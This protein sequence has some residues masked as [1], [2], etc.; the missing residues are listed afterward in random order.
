MRVLPCLC[1][2]AAAG[3]CAVAHAD[4]PATPTA[5][6]PPAFER[7]V[8]PVLKASCF[9]C[10]GENEEPEGGL[11][12]RL[13]RRIVGGG[14]SGPAVV[15]GDHNASLLYQRVRDGEMPPD[16]AHRLTDS[17]IET[18]ARWID[19]GAPT[20]RPEPESIDGDVFTE[21]ELAHWAWQPVTR[22][23]VPAV[24]DRARL[25][26]PIDAFLLARLQEAGF[27]FSPEADPTTLLRRLFLD[28]IGLPPT[29]EQADRFLSDLQPGAYERLVDELL[30]SPH[31]GE[32]WGRHWLDAAGYADSEGYSVED[33]VR[34][35]AWK[36]RDYV[37]RAFN[38]DRPFDRFIREQ[39][40]GDEMI[41]S[42]LDNLTPEDAEKLIATGYL[43][44]APD[45]TAA[46]VDDP[47]L[48]RNDVMAET[49][50]IVSSSLMGVTLGCAQCHDHRYD[51]IPQAD[52][53]RFRAFFEPALNWKHWRTPAQRLVSLYTD[54]DRA[55]AAEIEA[56]AQCVLAERS[57]LEQ[58]LIRETLD[59]EIAKLPAEVQEAAK[60][61]HATPENDRT[62]E[63]KALFKQYPS[64][65]VNP[66]TLYLY[67]SAAAAQLKELADKAEAI[68][69]ARP[70][71]EFVH[72]LTELPEEAP[73]T[74]VFARGDYQQPKAEVTPAFL[75][76]V[77][78]AAGAATV[79]ADDPARPTT[80]RRT[81]LAEHLTSG[82]H[83]LVARVV[84]NR[85]WMHHFGR[86]LVATPADFGALGT[87]PSHP[88]LLDWL[89]S[90]FVSSGW[91]VKHVH[92]LIVLSS[93][94]RQSLR[95]DAAQ[96][97]ADPDNLLYGGARLVRLDAEV[98]RDGVLAASGRLNDALYGRPVP[99][100][101]DETGRW[102]L[103]IENLNA[104]RPGAVI[105]LNGEEFRRSVYV[106]VRRS[107]PV[108]VLDTFDWPRMSPNCDCR[109]PS[110]STPQSLMLMNS[111]FVVAESRAFAERVAR[112]AG[113][114]CARQID[115]AW[116]L[117]LAR[118]PE[119][120]ERASAIQFLDEQAGHFRERL[121]QPELSE[122]AKMQ[123]PER[124]ALA[125][126]CQ[127]L[128][129]SNAFL[130]A[131]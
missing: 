3:A 91:S 76:V 52:Y 12:L 22:P 51:P 117:A 45:G 1:L 30:A 94:Y 54:A 67:D 29:P 120:S 80:G 33:P 48:A 101:A 106:Q 46:R 97:A 74:Y 73:A 31:Y 60:T 115:L 4:Q 24:H 99:V 40:A 81:H 34:D 79:P 125:S 27:G 35:W 17:Q 70:P 107:R 102:I 68:R 71:E 61:A 108:A 72:A 105:P 53:Y 55:K 126:L 44:M 28:L 82:R 104:G 119:E 7:D 18:I 6:A 86:G 88:E 8:R 20:Q 121:G 69:A 57:R 90:E 62:T 5:S 124:L 122:L 96:D 114:D 56:E 2:A 130:Y 16:P 118:W 127:T 78:R 83:P 65:N 15:P 109:K 93:A 58:Q 128:L 14:D 10:H 13:A 37:I 66:G 129:S 64:L 32:R 39:L 111:D 38:E 26:T 98:I 85:L 36:Y 123:S 77:A 116:R 87:P 113:D 19:A 42:P 21:E 92:R 41:A 89:A 110:T 63:Q 75:S 11:D 9:Q 131:D 23:A 100:M 103:G 50:K 112:D 25:S 49:I 47:D 43:R 95:T 84:V 59:K